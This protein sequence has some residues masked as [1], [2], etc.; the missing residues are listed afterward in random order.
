MRLAAAGLA[1]L[2]A[3]GSSL[4]VPVIEAQTATKV[5]RIGTLRPGSRPTAPDWKQRWVFAEALRDLGW[6]QGRNIVI[7]DRWA[8]GRTERLPALASELVRQG[9]DVIAT[10]SWPAA[11]AAKQATTTIPIV[12]AGTGDPVATGL[13]QSLARPGGNITGLGDLDTELSA[14]RLEFLKEAV[15]NLARLAVLWNSA[16][17]GMTLRARAIQGAARTLGVTVRPLGVQE[18]EELDQAFAAMTQE[19][20][21]ALLVVSDLLTMLHRKRIIEFTAQHRM[22]AMY[23]VR[24]FVDA[25]GLISYGQNFDDSERR[26]ALYVDRILKGAKPAELPVEQPTRFELV[27]NLKTAQALGLAVPET[28]LLRADQVIR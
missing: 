3:F 10:R 20:P 25:G 27:V 26:A 13:V 6:V 4:A 1:V 12:I 7:E 16:D 9:V 8:D 24:G 18:P 19:R 15:P 23:E 14:K 17:G 21:D 22:P 5:Y 11:V 2:A 28:L